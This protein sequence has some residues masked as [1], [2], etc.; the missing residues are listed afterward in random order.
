MPHVQP[1]S[2]FLICSPEYYLVRGT[3]YIASRYVVCATNLTHSKSEIPAMWSTKKLL[4]D[5]W[6]YKS[7]QQEC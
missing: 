4:A 1:I 2:L 3:D 6:E 7:M 5:M